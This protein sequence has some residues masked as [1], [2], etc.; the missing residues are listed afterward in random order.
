MGWLLV[1]DEADP[2]HAPLSEQLRRASTRLLA[3]FGRRLP[4][5]QC[6]YIYCRAN[7]RLSWLQYRTH[8]DTSR[9]END[10]YL[11]RW[12]LRR[13]QVI[14]RPG[15]LQK[16]CLHPSDLHRA[17]RDARPKN[18]LRANGHCLH[19]HHDHR[20]HARRD[21][22]IHRA[23]CGRALLRDTSERNSDPDYLDARKCY[24]YQPYLNKNTT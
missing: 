13:H 16:R 15:P 18:H 9:D 22:C 23:N 19:H 5:R 21:S 14:S 11:A 8:C 2:H 7:Q 10:H 12:L 3:E 1:R 4:E 24:V 20:V 17:H 6:H